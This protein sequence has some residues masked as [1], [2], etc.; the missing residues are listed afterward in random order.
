MNRIRLKQPLLKLNTVSPYSRLYYPEEVVA[1]AIAKLP[2]DFLYGDIR[3]IDYDMRTV[4]PKT[5][6]FSLT[7][8]HVDNHVVYGDVTINKDK[9]GILLDSMPVED[10]R[11][12]L[13]SKITRSRISEK[14][15]TRVLAC[16]FFKATAFSNFI[17]HGFY[18]DILTCTK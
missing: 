9:F 1:E 11:F 5:I 7:N 3:L 18:N 13:T 17:E 2:R 6:A 12:S 4:N 16:E 15:Y 14:G 10:I 8:I